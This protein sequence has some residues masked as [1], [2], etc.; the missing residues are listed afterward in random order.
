MPA[1]L[2]RAE[3]A[4]QPLPSRKL[5]TDRVQRMDAELE[6]RWSPTSVPTGFSAMALV[7]SD[8]EDSAF[9]RAR[10]NPEDV[11]ATSFLS[12]WADLDSIWGD[13][14]SRGW[15][16][17][18]REALERRHRLVRYLM[19]CGLIDLGSREADAPTYYFTKEEL[20]E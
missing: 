12:A 9:I 19:E 14:L 7:W 20:G 8:S 3:G 15:A 13:P 6:M 1:D 16:M 4:Y 17:S 5:L 2:D 10:E 18:W 11:P